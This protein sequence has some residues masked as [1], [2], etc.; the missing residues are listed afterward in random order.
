[1]GPVATVYI[2]A[3]NLYRRALQGTPYRWLDVRAMCEQILTKFDVGSVKYFTAHVKAPKNDPQVTLRQR[4]YL[5]ALQAHSGVEIH[6]GQFRRD[7]RWMESHPYEEDEEGAP[8]K[9]QVRKTEEKGSD[10]NLATHLVWDALHEASD[11]FV[12]LSNDSDLVTP[13]RRLVQ[14]KGALVGIISPVANPSRALMG[15]GAFQKQLRQGVLAN[16]QLPDPV[17]DGEGHIWRRPESWR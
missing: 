2:D 14:E 1:M 3:F 17:V 16:S 4:T 12:V 6:L 13:I 9:V 11:A 8:V 5:E 15:T 7:R 10:V